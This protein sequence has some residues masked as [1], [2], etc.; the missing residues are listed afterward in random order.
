[1]RIN[2][3]KTSMALLIGEGLLKA[4][5]YAVNH[6]FVLVSLNFFLERL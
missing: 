2:F 1:M 6:V 4:C 5:K 3:F